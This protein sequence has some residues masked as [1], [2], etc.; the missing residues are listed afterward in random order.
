[1]V[2]NGSASHGVRCLTMN[3]EDAIQ[4]I[5]LTIQ[6]ELAQIVSSFRVDA[7]NN[8]DSRIASLELTRALTYAWW[9]TSVSRREQDYLVCTTMSRG[10]NSAMSLFVTPSHMEVPG[11]PN[12][13]SSPESQE[14]A[15]A[16]LTQL[17][18]LRLARRVVDL[19]RA[20]LIE[21]VEGSSNKLRFQTIGDSG[22]AEDDDVAAHRW[23]SDLAI[24]QDDAEYRDL[25]AQWSYIQCLLERNVRVYARHYIG[26]DTTPELDN[27]F[28]RLAVLHARRSYGHEAFSWDAQ[29]GGL[30]YAAFAA[31]AV[32]LVGSA[33]KHAAF[34]TELSRM[35]PNLEIRNLLVPWSPVQ[36]KARSLSLQLEIDGEAAVQILRLF[37]GTPEY[38]NRFA[39]VHDAPIPPF[40]PAARDEIHFSVASAEM[41]PYGLL[42]RQLR[43]Q[44]PQDYFRNVDQRE[45]QFR[46]DLRW[47]LPMKRV[48]FADKAVQLRH[49][50]KSV[51]DVDAVALS[52]DTGTLGL[53]QLKWQDPFGGDLR[54]RRNRLANLV[55]SANRW[56][57]A[58]LEWLEVHGPQTLVKLAQFRGV[59]PQVHRVILFVVGRYHCNFSQSRPDSRAVW[60]SWAQL[61]RAVDAGGLSGDPLVSLKETIERKRDECRP[62]RGSGIGT[63]HLRDFTIETSYPQPTDSR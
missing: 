20:G 58:V 46:E 35:K 24:S 17:G 54:E 52:K 30:P 16:V 37:T 9:R 13:P 44:Y 42:L 50:S 62:P 31:T 43:E 8:I 12:A 38:F 25:Q 47:V 22:V 14:W 63:L 56:V 41:Q 27:Y 29:F 49:A 51:T 61:L 59:I 36:S 4:R 40:V 1:M 3:A 11:V 18:L 19:F 34:A 6:Q 5:E 57:Q 2:A 60:C 21:F 23:L 15:D 55:P 32:T 53:F 33:L 45:V 7:A 48:H 28:H 26:Y 10:F 39:G